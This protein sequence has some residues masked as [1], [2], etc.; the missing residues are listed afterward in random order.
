MKSISIYFLLLTVLMLSAVDLLFAEKKSYPKYKDHT[1][2]FKELQK[3]RSYCIKLDSDSCLFKLNAL[4]PA[5]EA[6]NIP[7]TTLMWEAVEAEYYFHMDEFQKSLDLLF[8]LYEK[9]KEQDDNF[10]IIRFAMY[11]GDCYRYMDNQ[12]LALKYY[13]ES[14]EQQ[15]EPYSKIYFMVGDRI[16]SLYLYIAEYEPSIELYERLME[17]VKDYDDTMSLR[18]MTNNLSRAYSLKGD[19]EKG[20]ELALLTKELTYSSSKARPMLKRFSDLLLAVSYRENKRYQEAIDLLEVILSDK[21]LNAYTETPY[22]AYFQLMDCYQQ[23]GQ[24]EKAKKYYKIGR[25]YADAREAAG[26][27]LENSYE[28]LC[29]YHKS[30][31]N[32]KAALD[33]HKKYL[34]YQLELETGEKVRQTLMLRNE[35]EVKLKQSEINELAQKNKA[36][37]LSIR[38][39]NILISSLIC[40]FLLASLIMYLIFKQRNLRV[41]TEHQ[42]LEQKLL[43]SQM[44][45]HFI[46]NTVSVIQSLILANENKRAAKY[47]TKFSRLMRV[48]LENSAEKFVSLRSEL[49]AI[50][51]YVD[52]QLIRFN[53]AFEFELQLDPSIDTEDI[54]VP[55]MLI[56][57]F[58]E[59][60]IEHGIRKVQN[61]KV[62]VRIFEQEGYLYCEVDDN[63]IGLHASQSLHMTKK[64]SLSTQ[65]TKERLSHFGRETGLPVQLEINDNQLRGEAGTSVSIRLPYKSTV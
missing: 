58:V 55:P 31:G 46:F 60:A 17:E 45:P 36:N 53:E 34:E 37:D 23:L 42:L 6:E 47:L 10:H 54:L 22:F 24:K 33:A 49:D 13:N 1:P 28:L 3:L 2:L 18:N 63:G 14:M 64:K 32:Y 8:P 39:R 27:G 44:N 25:E 61:G 4:K 15:Q 65:I 20:L 5:V 41:D 29:D 62:V 50:E 30:N 51:D 11:I 7:T 38:Q 52:L 16:A 12:Y 21:K 56:Q 48:I 43:R 19:Y 59:N 35:F 57:P 40:L 26:K 9:A